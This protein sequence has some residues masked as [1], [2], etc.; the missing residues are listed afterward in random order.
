MMSDP[1]GWLAR[2]PA[3][4]QGEAFRQELFRRTAGVLRRRRWM[5]RAGVALALAACYAAGVLAP[6]PAVPHMDRSADFARGDPE[7]TV[8]LPAEAPAV[9]KDRSAL[10]LEWQALD[11]TD[12]RAELFRKA[13]D[14]YLEE[15]GDVPSA[16]RCYR[17]ALDA[18]DTIGPDDSWL[19]MA[20][21]QA[22]QK[23]KRDANTDS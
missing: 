2:T 1:E 21:K 18:G 8:P 20:L 23:E 3:P 19:L 17:S 10:A 15:W 5:R 11:S 22:K 14:R 16:L 12:G 9:A 6:P 13:G 7:A 4:P